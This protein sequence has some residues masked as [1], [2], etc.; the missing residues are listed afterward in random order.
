MRIEDLKEG[1]W[2]CSKCHQVV[3]ITDGR[4]PF[5]GTQIYPIG[6]FTGYM[7]AAFVVGLGFVILALIANDSD[8]FGSFLKK[9]LIGVGVF[10]ILIGGL[11]GALRLYTIK[12][13]KKDMEKFGIA[14]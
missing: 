5:C 8:A 9:L 12:R 2:I 1:E 3:K 10:A 14:K 6:K 4:C 11:C 7:I 13:K